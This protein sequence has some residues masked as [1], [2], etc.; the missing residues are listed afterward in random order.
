LLTA[1]IEVL[2][3]VVM[4]SSICWD[5]T[6]LNGVI[7]PSQETELYSESHLP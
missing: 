5:I 2:T 4:K 3:A 6:R 1:E 7:G